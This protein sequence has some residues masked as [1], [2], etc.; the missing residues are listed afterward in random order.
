MKNLKRQI[1]AFF[2][3]KYLVVKYKW[4]K[5]YIL[6]PYAKHGELVTD[7]L[8]DLMKFSGDKAYKNWIGHNRELYKDW[9]NDYIK[10]GDGRL[11]IIE[12]AEKH[13]I[14]YPLSKTQQG[15]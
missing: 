5:G 7:Y 10:N 2:H 8:L 9:R 11:N 6:I 14:E 3:A 1:K 12:Y 4:I 13:G 15:R